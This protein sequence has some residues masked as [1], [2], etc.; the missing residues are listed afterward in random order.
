MT[1]LLVLMALTSDEPSWPHAALLLVL[2]VAGA[3]WA[4]TENLTSYGAASASHRSR[5][6]VAWALLGALSLAVL[7]TSIWSG[8][9]AEVSGRRNFAVTAG[10]MAAGF[11]GVLA[12]RLWRALSRWDSDASSD[13]RRPSDG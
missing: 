8:F 7:A 10:A 12:V 11:Y 2:A 5:S 13:A 6:L 9:E 4:L 3:G 1:V